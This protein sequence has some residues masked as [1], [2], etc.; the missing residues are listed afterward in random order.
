[1][2]YDLEYREYYE[3]D[4]ERFWD[5]RD[6]MTGRDLDVYPFLDGA[7]GVVLEYGCGAGSLIYNLAKEARFTRC[8]AVDV[9]EQALGR[10][11]HY[12]EAE[13]G[14]SKKLLCSTP[15]GD[16]L[17]SQPDASFDVLISVATLEHVWNPY[18]VLDELHRLAKED[19]TLICSV[20]NYGYIK[21]VLSLFVGRQ[22]RTGTD[23]P[24]S[25]WRREGWDGMHLHTFTKSSF[26]TLLRECGWIPVRWRGCG[27][28]Y[29]WTGVGVLRRRFPGMWSGELMVSCRKGARPIGL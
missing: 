12:W 5:P 19:A 14:G 18:V 22:P 9:S 29:A 20:P 28:R 26:E 23:L 4:S 2:S 1:M 8:L 13:Q 7:R 16:R 11:R 17:P 25:D 27:T 3:K 6:G 10:L 24:V 15:D 21:H